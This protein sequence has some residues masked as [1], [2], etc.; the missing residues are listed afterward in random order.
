[1]EEKK[2]IHRGWEEFLEG[3]S[4]I[5]A[6]ELQD[7]LRDWAQGDGFAIR[8]S[9]EEW[10]NWEQERCW[11]D[12]LVVAFESG[13]PICRIDSAAVD[14]ASNQLL[15]C[16]KTKKKGASR[17]PRIGNDCIRSALL[18]SGWIVHANLADIRS[19]LVQYDDVIICADTNILI[20][21]V[22]SATL[23][24]VLIKHTQPNWILIAIPKV[25]MAEIETYASKQFPSGYPTWRARTTQ[26]A[27]QEVL[28]LDTSKDEIYRGLSI[29]TVGELPDDF[30]H[31]EGDSV[32][33]DSAIRRQ[34]RDFLRSITFH[35]GSFLISQDR[36]NVMMARAEGIEGLYLQKPEWEEV[37][38]QPMRAEIDRRNLSRLVY[39]L[40]VSFGVIS[41]QSPLG[42]LLIDISW[43]GK[44]VLDW[45]H[46]RI[47]I[48][49]WEQ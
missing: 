6:Q 33:K 18:R 37:A 28:A 48:R 32:R 7:L 31:M 24:P 29:M 27:L 26:R 22:F 3:D 43:P 36:V 44:R 11:C 39:E 16:E 49:A 35:K 34:F 25:V 30:K 47:L 1:M 2:F 19:R 23:L 45:E 41:L 12:A 15:E 42:N 17:H 20:D 40:C 4:I 14:E 5:A 8:C 38:E 13:K 9:L 46:A 21:C 10:N